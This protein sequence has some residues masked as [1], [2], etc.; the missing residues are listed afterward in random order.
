MRKLIT[1]LSACVLMCGCSIFNGGVM[2]VKPNKADI[3]KEK[4]TASSEH[5]TFTAKGTTTTPTII[6]GEKVVPQTISALGQQLATFPPNTK[7]EWNI[8]EHSKSSQSMAESIVGTLTL[9]KSSSLLIYIGTFILIAGIVC[10]FMVPAGF[11]KSIGYI[12]ILTGIGF[13][14]GGVC[15]EQYP[16]IFAYIL[17][18]IVGAT[19]YTVY[20][21]IKTT[22]ASATT[23]TATTQIVGSW[24]WAL[25]ELK[26]VEGQLSGI[27]AVEFIETKLGI[28]Q[29]VKTKEVVKDVR[30]N[31]K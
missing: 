12:A 17:L 2:G 13:V 31:I 28:A 27:K 5:L 29:D 22:N 15:A 30:S 14:A 18:L 21:L 25:D 11:G 9:D 24:D 3:K 10:A 8:G 7:V 6:P 4:Q 19:G 16:S 26:K 20:N 1:L 23:S